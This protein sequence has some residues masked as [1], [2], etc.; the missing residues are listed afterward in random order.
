MSPATKIIICF[1]AALTTAAILRL[2]LGKKRELW[3][4]RQIPKSVITLRTRLSMYIAIGSPKTWQGMVICL[5]LLGIIALECYLI[6]L[7]M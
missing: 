5:I 7:Y 6:C 3:F 2:I 4:K 1:I